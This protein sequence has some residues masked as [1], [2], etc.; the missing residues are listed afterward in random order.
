M[1]KFLKNKDKIIISL[2][3]LIL[4]NL[5]VLDLSLFGS[6]LVEN[7]RSSISSKIETSQRDQIFEEINPSKGYELN[8]KYGDLGPELLSFGVIDLDKFKAAQGQMSDEELNILTKGSNQTIKITRENSH[9]LF[10]FFWAL[11]LANNTKILTDGEMQSYGGN[12]GN[13]ASTGG[14]PLLRGIV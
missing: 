10:N 9:F 13:F 11:G 5:I 7:I 2:L 14:W 4:L 3:G 6:P 1:K 12:P 8:V